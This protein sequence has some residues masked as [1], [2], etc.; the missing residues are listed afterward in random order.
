MKR[1][2]LSVLAITF[3]YLFSHAQGQATNFNPNAQSPVIYLS[4]L[5]GRRATEEW[6]QTAIKGTP[7]FTKSWGTASVT[8]K[9]NRTFKNVPVRLNCVNNTLHY[10]TS[11]KEEMIAPDGAIKELLLIDSAESGVKE[12]Q[13]VSG[14]P[15]IGRH[16]AFTFYERQLNGKTQLLV[17]TKKRMLESRPLGSAAPEKE[18]LGVEQY[19]VFKDGEMH[20][21]QKG[22]DFLLNLLSDKRDVVESY[23]KE[24][25]LKCRSEE[26]LKKVLSFYNSNS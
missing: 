18:Y 22:K 14:Y 16:T 11:N 25:R 20:E 24:Q 23:I 17:F 13:F 10:L 2:L 5:Q 7:F 4:D 26:D 6:N 21:W 15:A 8:L 3:L 12:Y 9:D 19:F 1:L